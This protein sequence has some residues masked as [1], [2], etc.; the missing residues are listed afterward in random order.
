VGRGVSSLDLNLSCTLEPTGSAFVGPDSRGSQT[1]RLNDSYLFVFVA[2]GDLAVVAERSATQLVPCEAMLLHS[3]TT[4][5]V[6]FHPGPASEFYAVKFKAAPH[7]AQRASNPLTVPAKG[8]VA[9]PERLTDLLR[10][11]VAEQ[12]HR[13]QAPWALSNLLVLILCEFSAAAGGSL[14]ARPISS[15]LETIASTVDAFIAAH[16]RE[17]ISTNDIAQELRYSPGYLERAYRKERG[18]SVRSAIHLR[19]I[20]EARAQLI[21]QREMHVS[22]IAAQCGYDDAA[23]FR[24]VFKRTTNM[25]P[26]RF[27]TINSSRRAG[28]FTRVG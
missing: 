13:R 4:R 7:A 18:I 19:R 2:H 1:L 23:Y 16:Y 5:T 8:A 11:Y 15:G 12:R 14:E 26:L 17:A 28:G 22:E 9:C 3:G 25:T 6:A 20:R 24:R 21:L 27:R 10:R